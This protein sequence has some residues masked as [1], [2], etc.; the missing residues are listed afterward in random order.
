ML[1]KVLPLVLISVV[2]AAC[3]SAP[4]EPAGHENPERAVIAWF[5][6]I[7]NGNAVGASN[8]IHSET[9]ALILG[10]ENGLDAA[11]IAT[12]LDDGVPLET[13]AAYWASFADG[14]VEF[15]SRPVSTLTVGESERF[16]SEGFE[17]ASVPV[18]GGVG[19]G[20]VVITRM[21]DGGSWEVDLVAS[22][23]DGF[24]QLLAGEYDGLPNDEVGDR[25][26]LAYAETV[27]PSLWAA[28][29]DGSFGDDFTRTAMAI[30]DS[31]DRGP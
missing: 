23:G 19:S 3:S 8:A 25:V 12:Y 16:T 27:V 11:A 5:E 1:K 7:D 24:A 14:F 6:A 20:S 13:Q 17:F 29:T 30:I 10:I 26:R 2:A 31:V 4:A 22:L 15:A 28:M 18:G 9:L 21:R